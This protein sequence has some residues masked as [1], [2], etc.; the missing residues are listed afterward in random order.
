MV[1]LSRS[2][3][4]VAAMLTVAGPAAALTKLAPDR[5]QTVALKQAAP[6]RF[7][8]QTRAGDYLAGFVDGGPAGSVT[9]DLANADGGPVRRLVTAGR[10]R[11]EFRFVAE[12]AGQVLQVTAA[13]PGSV[14]LG[15]SRHL[16]REQQKLTPQPPLSPAIA[17]LSAEIAA[18]GTAD[19]FWKETERTGAPLVEPGPD[20]KTILTFLYR[21]ARR[22]VRIF[23]APSGDHDEMQRLPGSDVWYR[24]YLVP[25]ETRLSYKLAPD[26]PDLPGSARE[27][28]IAILATA[29]ADSLNR[30]PW[31]GDAPDRFNRESTVV[32]QAAPAQPWLDRGQAP[33]GTTT[34]GSIASSR[35]GNSRQITVYRPPGFDASRPDNLLL[36]VFDGPEYQSKVPTPRML[37]AMIAAGVLPPTVAVFVANAD[38]DAR[39]RELP[40]NPAF[41]DFMAEEL[42]PRVLAETGL[43]HD[44]ARTIL[45]GSSFGGLAA[46]TV[47]F[48]HPARFG[49]AISLSGSFWWH[50]PGSDPASPNHVAALFARS[51]RL[52]VRFFLSAGL[53]ETGSPSHGD[54][55]LETSRHLRDVLV[56]RDYD[57]T[58]RDYAGGHDYLVWR[59]ALADGLLALFG[60]R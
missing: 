50:P 55:I 32:L 12:K 46:A 2:S 58:Y 59:G 43:K 17:R 29:Q 54:G 6:E 3:A 53:F 21:G 11:S 57:V 48:R 14:T 20:G 7:D 49:N 42:L 45:A 52:P 44:A 13:T 16:A 47:A 9:V 18:G 24:S 41:A 23:G 25:A 8:P 30:H 38:R 40:G 27:R 34:D 33:G 4:L 22:N 51:P 10:G 5:P 39:A 31:P 36:F 28:R 26:V 60:R 37:D 1:S 19:A 15:L 35:L 56:A